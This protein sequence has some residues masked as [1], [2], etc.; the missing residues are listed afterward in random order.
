MA[1]IARAGKLEAIYLLHDR[2]WFK[3]ICFTVN[4][5]SMGTRTMAVFVPEVLH[6]NKFVPVHDR[7]DPTLTCPM[8][9]TTEFT[10]LHGAPG[11]PVVYMEKSNRK[12]KTDGS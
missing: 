10:R 9:T 6:G 11:E 1:N 5:G 12:R 2:R 4:A 8:P 3:G 7:P